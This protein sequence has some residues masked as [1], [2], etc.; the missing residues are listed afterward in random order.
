MDIT[1]LETPEIVKTE[2][3]GPDMVVIALAATAATLFVVNFINARRNR[4]ATKTETTIETP[5]K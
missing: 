1:T 5:A 2:K 3:S 4:K